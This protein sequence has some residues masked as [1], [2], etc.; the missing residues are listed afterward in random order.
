MEE[1]SDRPGWTN[2]P[3]MGVGCH[4]SPD[5]VGYRRNGED[6]EVQVDEEQASGV[7]RERCDFDRVY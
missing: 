4:G 3:R 5:G 2:M 1:D 7:D 6:G